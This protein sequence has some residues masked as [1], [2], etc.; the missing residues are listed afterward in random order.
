MAS[1][2]HGACGK[3][4]MRRVI[5][6]K[7]LLTL[8]AYLIGIPFVVSQTR[9]H[10]VVDAASPRMPEEGEI[11]SFEKL[12]HQIPQIDGGSMGTIYP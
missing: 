3:A 5:F 9:I 6:L 4:I 10:L 7:V 1:Q 2:D 11:S 8:P 12:P